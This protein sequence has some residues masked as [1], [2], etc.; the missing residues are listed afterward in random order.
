MIDF[1]MRFRASYR[2]NVDQDVGRVS[3]EEKLDLAT[4]PDTATLQPTSHKAA[5]FQVPPK[6]IEEID[7]ALRNSM[8]L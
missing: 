4:L 5:A 6:S 8:A 3:Y 2:R 1:K 7:L